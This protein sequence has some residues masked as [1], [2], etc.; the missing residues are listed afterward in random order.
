MEMI[1]ISSVAGKVNGRFA[2]ENQGLTD[3]GM[4]L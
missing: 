2:M 3:K 4:T 1:K